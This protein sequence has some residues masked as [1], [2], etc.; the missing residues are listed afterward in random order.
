MGPGVG[1]SIAVGEAG[2]QWYGG[3]G[4]GAP[5]GVRAYSYRNGIDGA[6]RHQTRADRWGAEWS[7]GRSPELHDPDG[8]WQRPSARPNIGGM[9]IIGAAPPTRS[10]VPSFVIGAA[11]GTI[12]IVSGLTFAF[13]TLL[14]PYFDRVARGGFGG[15]AGPSGAAAWFAAVLLG[16]VFLSV[17][18]AR[19]AGLLA[20]VRSAAA[21]NP[22]ILP[23]HDP[24]DPV[25]ALNVDVGDGR[26]IP[27]LVLG[28]FGAAVIRD[29]PDASVAR[30]QGPYW[31]AISDQG[32]VRIESPL[33]RAA[34]DAERARRWFAHDERDY[35][36][37]VYAAVVTRDSALPRTPTCAVIS[38]SQLEPWLRSLPVQRSLTE[39][40]RAQLLA[41]LRGGR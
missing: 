8:S 4:P 27:K 25:L 33:D 13:A 32:W 18:T 17:G 12:L 40:R 10:R 36:V 35:V 26:P 29:L 38:E 16:A 15:S 3:H 22:V 37:R 6:P 7:V 19:L 24:D 14:T 30:H 11:T 2:G 9:Q 20:D 5:T 41:M 21:A 34:R 39:A 23:A 1:R 28:K 31:E